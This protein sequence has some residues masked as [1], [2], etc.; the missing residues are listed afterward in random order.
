MVIMKNEY[1][2]MS[3]RDDDVMMVVSMK[4]IMEHEVWLEMRMVVVK[5]WWLVM[6]MLM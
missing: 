3:M 2:N 6:E 4:K 1:V 5:I